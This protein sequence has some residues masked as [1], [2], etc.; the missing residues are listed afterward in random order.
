MLS[1]PPGCLRAQTLCKVAAAHARSL[2]SGII[3]SDV[4]ARNNLIE[5]YSECGRMDNA[6]K[7]FDEIPLRNSVTWNLLLSGCNEKFQFRDSWKVFVDMH[8]NGASMDGFT[9]GSVLS[10]C[11][12]LEGAALGE[13]VHGYVT[14]SGFVSDGYFRTGMIDLY[15]KSRRIH[16][17]VKVLHDIDCEKNVV[18]WN[19]V[20]SGAV[21]N[22]ES[23]TALGIF[24]QMC[25]RES[26]I[27]NAFTFSSVLTA[28]A[29][30]KDL[31]FGRAVHGLAAKSGDDA[32]IFV[33]TAIVDFYSKCG[34]IHDAV[35]QF[36]A[37]PR[38]NVVSW[39]A[40]LNGF[41]LKGDPISALVILRE[42]HVS[43]EEIN[44]FTASSAIAACAARPEMIAETSQ[45]HCW[46]HKNGL[47][48]HPVVRSSLISTYSKSGRIDLSETAFA[49][50]SDDGS[51]Q[52]QQQP[53]I[54]AS[55]ISAFVDA[56]LCDEAVFFFGRM[57]KSGVA[58]DRFSASVVL[59]AVDRL[60]LGR[61]VHCYVLKAGLA[62]ETSV[63]SSIG[64]M[65]SKC[66]DL[67]DSLKAFDLV[68]TKDCAW[69]TS[70]I[71][72]FVEHGFGSKA[73]EFF[74]EGFEFFIPDGKLL[75]ALLNAFTDQKSLKLGKEIH[76]FALRS[77]FDLHDSL[78]AMY[79]RCSDLD[80][81][82]TTMT[83]FET[84]VAK[85][86][87]ST[88][89]SALAKNG[90]LREAMN[91]VL[92]LQTL[93]SS[94]DAA[95]SLSSILS[96][97]AASGEPSPGIQLHGYI[98]KSGM[99]SESFLG[100]SLLTMYSKCGALD[101]SR[102]VF[103]AIPDPDLVTWTAM[104]V[105]CGDHGR[106][107][108][109]LELF[110]EMK[111]SGIDPDEAAFVGILSACS[112]SGLVEEGQFHF[113]SMVEE[114]GM[115]PGFRHCACMVDVLGRAGRLEEAKD[116]VAGWLPSESGM[117]ETLM[118][119]CRVHGEDGI[120]KVAADRVMDLWRRRQAVGGGGAYVSVS[121]IGAEFGDWESVA[122]VRERMRREGVKRM[123]PGW[124][125]IV[126]VY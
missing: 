111:G 68:E 94:S 17:A 88:F 36:E 25:R 24:S 120:G 65:Y 26:L 98:I 109:A 16:D 30:S 105:S 27:P 123:N 117:W 75:S 102:K 97:L 39:T 52:Q 46:I 4:Y 79:S 63:G 86:S 125:S 18:C 122:K 34:S 23:S 5:A 90:C 40:I 70:M 95:L 31:E 104:I 20:V 41:A 19:A 6:F 118:G 49:E 59:A 60:F 56:G 66:G 99:E 42:M 69:L 126:A 73:V 37:M 67:N 81:A 51:K 58:P 35:R 116:F 112:H 12:A 124:S 33:G 71:A 7:V 91:N 83:A 10:A 119:G 48:S 2:K 96:S 87:S 28:C 106:G 82:R 45:I 14:K 29:A 80:S 101:E 107:S 85:S 53:A 113:R 76:G 55:M 11:S 115:E 43:G 21:K 1:N 100:S 50:G 78:L 32:D 72:G 108:E 89:I 9:Y 62:S 84:P 121:N 3:H 110:E 103:R 74:R 38:R 57:L 44:A 93:S 64:S 22:D 15:A 77:G 61:Q 54:W 8:R 114:Y 13:Q 92:K 47:D